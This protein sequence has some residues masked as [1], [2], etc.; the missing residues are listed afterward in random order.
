MASAVD[1][2]VGLREA[3]LPRARF[4]QDPR[5]YQIAALAGLLAY[6]IAGLG[7]DVAPSRIGA[8][9]A[10]S[11]L[12][13]YL[14][15]RL[16]ALPFEP[17]SALITAL[18]LSLLLRTD[19]PSLA[20]AGAVIAIGSKFALRIG[21]KHV[22]NPTNL[23]IVLLLATSESAWVSPGQWGSPT[24]FAFLVVCLGGLVIHRSTRAEVTVVFLASWAALLVGR[25][26]Y[27]GEPMTIP[28]HRLE[29]GTLLI[30]AFFMISD[31]RT[32]PD[33]RAGRV[34]FALVV[35]L[36]AFH[37]QFRLFRTNGLLFALALSAPIVPV[38]DR[39][40][41]GPRYRWSKVERSLP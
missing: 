4:A 24:F 22:F 15:G 28:A 5:Y 19:S 20:L 17:R 7:F 25:S 40:L 16:F 29:S 30:F 32:T 9:V 27:L 6:G 18:S 11:L 2:S 23:A 37:I 34:L 13:Q 1:S 14:C 8:F 21:G 31:P 33:S 3:R 35:A 36:V 38:L 12:T 39:V 10:A 41:P 26:L